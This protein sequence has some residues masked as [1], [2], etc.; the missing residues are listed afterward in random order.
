MPLKF[1]EYR[2][3][4]SGHRTCRFIMLNG[5][6]PVEC[7]ASWELMDGIEKNSGNVDRD[8]Q[9][10]RLQRPLAGI[11]ERKF[12]SFNDEDRPKSIE[13]TSRDMAFLI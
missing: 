10:E 7:T 4:V 2:G 6:E 11:A 5:S 3:T 12:F 8:Q 13:L 1:G 9:F